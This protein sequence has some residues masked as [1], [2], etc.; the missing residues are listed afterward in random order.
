MFF[1]L[2]LVV[3]EI[4]QDGAVEEMGDVVRV[5]DKAGPD[6]CSKLWGYSVDDSPIEIRFFEIS[7]LIVPEEFFKH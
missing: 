2:F 7:V 3:F 4:S 6:E 1:Q 5:G